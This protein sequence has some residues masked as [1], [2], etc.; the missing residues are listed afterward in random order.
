M[1]T[2][3]RGVVVRTPRGGDVAGPGHPVHEALSWRGQE[4][5]A[6]DFCDEAELGIEA[7][8]VLHFEYQLLGD[9]DGLAS[10]SINILWMRISPWVRTGLNSQRRLATVAF[11]LTAKYTR[12]EAQRIGD[13]WG[14]V[15]TAID[16]A[17]VVPGL[18]WLLFVGVP[19][20]LNAAYF[21][22]AAAHGRGVM[23]KWIYVVV[24]VQK[25]TRAAILVNWGSPTK[26][27]VLYYRPGE[28]IWTQCI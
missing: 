18:G 15:G 16:I 25:R 27:S 17:S 26:W 6:P 8:L 4:E 13:N 19:V 28:V 14:Q 21:R 12:S 11:V 5:L 24:L 3:D 1:R 22:L 2:G 10:R 9:L 7:H 23:V 20:Q